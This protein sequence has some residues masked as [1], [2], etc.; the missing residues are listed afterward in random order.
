MWKPYTLQGCL[1][2]KKQNSPVEYHNALGMVLLQV[3]RGVRF[4]MSEVPLKS[5]CVR[6]AP[7][8]RLIY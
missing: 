3:P 1:A 7:V 8:F 2:H 6:E 4:L 5:P